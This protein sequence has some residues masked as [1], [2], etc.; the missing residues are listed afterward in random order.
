[1]AEF[2]HNRLFNSKNPYQG[3]EKKV[4][5]VCSAGLLRSPTLAYVLASE[6]GFNTRAAGAD[7][8]HA[9][10]PIDVVLLHWADEICVMNEGQKL[11]IESMMKFFRKKNA[12]LS[13]N[14]EDTP[15]YVLDV[16]DRYARMDPELQVL[17]LDAYNERDGGDNEKTL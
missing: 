17:L 1:M 7:E 2:S 15:I 6:Y 9:L 10:I 12:H 16:P 11:A 5:C 3:E 4:L 14:L 8:G 13:I